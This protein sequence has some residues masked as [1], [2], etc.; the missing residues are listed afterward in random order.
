MTKQR[1]IGGLVGA[2]ALAVTALIMP[3]E[4]ERHVAY[5]DEPKIPSICYGHT[6]GVRL[7]DTADHD[8]CVVMLVSDVQPIDKA[9]NKLIKVPVSLE[10]RASWISFSFNAGIGAFASSTALKKLNAGDGAGACNEMLRWV[11]IKTAV[12]TG[13]A[14]TVPKGLCQTADRHLKISPGLQRRR[15]AER[16]L[17]L[18]D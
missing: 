4:G 13:E 6:S 11:C 8:D 15:L 12:G 16:Q 1:I 5:L 10:R 17:C 14:I 7:G 9:L 2:A 18:V 3:F